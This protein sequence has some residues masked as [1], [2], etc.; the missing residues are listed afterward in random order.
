MT[1][2]QIGA[3]VAVGVLWA[4]LLTWKWEAMS[5]WMGSLNPA[6]WMSGTVATSTAT[7]LSLGF[8]F[9]VLMLASATVILALH[10]VLAED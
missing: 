2:V 6:R 8:F 10:T 9:M 4:A 3:Y 5:A 1:A 7:S